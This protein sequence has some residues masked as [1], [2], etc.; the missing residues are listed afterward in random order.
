MKKFIKENWFKLGILIIILAVGIVFITSY[1][2]SDTEIV[3]LKKNCT[4]DAKDYISE[5]SSIRNSENPIYPMTQYDSVYSPEL[6][7]CLVN[8]SKNTSQQHWYYA[9]ID[10]YTEKE[11]ASYNYDKTDKEDLASQTLS[12]SYKKYDEMKNKYFSDNK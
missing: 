5:S 6:K 9:I 4:K 12:D 1:K 10:I 3:T 11:I 2:S 8:I 7:T